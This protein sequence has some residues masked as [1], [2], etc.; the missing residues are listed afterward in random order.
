[1]V[2]AH[3]LGEGGAA[4]HLGLDTE[5]EFLDLGLAVAV[6]DHVQRLH[7]GDART[8]HGAQL[9]GEEHDVLR[10]DLVAEG[11]QGLGFFSDPQ[12]QDALPA[13]FGLD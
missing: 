11:E 5:N 8:E 9:A 10:H 7:H 3:G 6:A 2:F 1:M 4:F 13:Q 12:W